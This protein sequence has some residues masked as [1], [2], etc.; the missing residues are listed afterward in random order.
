MAKKETLKEMIKRIIKEESQGNFENEFKN[1]LKEFIN[2]KI[3][4]KFPIKMASAS[5]TSKGKFVEVNSIDDIFK[6]IRSRVIK[7]YGS[8][9]NFKDKLYEPGDWTKTTIEKIPFDIFEL[10]SDFTNSSIPGL[11]IDVNKESGYCFEKIDSNAIQNKN[12]SSRMSPSFG[13]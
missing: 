1:Q 9:N 4:N 7:L 5:E 11:I 2:T 8:F 3:S 12:S 13:R 6:I 10:Y